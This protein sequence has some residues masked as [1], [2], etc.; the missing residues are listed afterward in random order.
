MLFLT[1]YVCPSLINYVLSFLRK[2]LLDKSGQLGKR[3]L[4]VPKLDIYLQDPDPRTVV[5]SFFVNSYFYGHYLS[6]AYCVTGSLHTFSQIMLKKPFK[7][8]YYLYSASEGEGELI[9][10]L[11]LRRWQSQDSDSK[12]TLLSTILVLYISL[13]LAVIT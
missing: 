13:S 3:G 7:A 6:S 1:S 10:F 11:H 12:P 5:S 2:H 9:Q 4:M 8:S